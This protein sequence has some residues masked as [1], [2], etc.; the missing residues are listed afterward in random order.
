MDKIQI[1]LQEGVNKKNIFK[2]EPMKN[3][4]SFKVGGIA[5][6]FIKIENIDELKYVID[7]SKELKVPLTVVGNGTNLLVTDKGIRGLVIKLDMKSF[8][9]EKYQNNV[10]LTAESGMSLPVLANIALKEEFTGFE[11]LSGIPGTIGGAIYM[12]AGAY[13]SE[14][15]DVVVK[16]KY[17]DIDTL[18]I[19]TLNLKDHKFEYRSS[20]FNKNKNWI[21]IETT[22]ELKYGN[23]NDIK[24]QMDEYLKSRKEKQP[25]EYPNAGSTFK[26]EGDI[27]TAKLIDECGLKGKSVGDAEVSTKHAGFVINKGKATASDILKLIDIIKTTVK[28]KTG[29]DINLEVEIVGEK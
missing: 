6:Y 25:M 11:F 7:L 24:A 2:D 1:K 29:V 20:I 5:D 3:H 10:I 4:T 23:R 14:M 9:F 22:F 16:T 28:D 8:K 15:K 26:R 27:I 21:I 17:L 12:N 18:K 13:G 19:K